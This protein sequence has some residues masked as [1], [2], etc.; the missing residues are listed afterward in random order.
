MEE[1]LNLEPIEV[2]PEMYEANLFGEKME[3]GKHPVFEESLTPGVKEASFNIFAFTD[4]IGARKKRDAWVLYRKALSLGM[5]PEE[6]F[7]K[8][9][10]Q[11]KSMMLASLTET[12]AEADMKP[13]PYNKAKGFL[14]NFQTSELRNLSTE[15]VIGYHHARR[16]EGEIETLVEKML[17]KL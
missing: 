5:V 13:F 10:W 12:P 14:K 3:A 2:H 17:L 4:A 8:F 16:G 6:M 7:Y 15:L 1:E 11:L 9:H